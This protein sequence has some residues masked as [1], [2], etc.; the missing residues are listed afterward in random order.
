MKD[1]EKEEKKK[2]PP[3]TTTHSLPKVEIVNSSIGNPNSTV[4]FGVPLGTLMRRQMQTAPGETVPLFIRDVFKY[5][6]DNGM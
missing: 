3:T 6:T 4:V 1:K 2:K 5:I